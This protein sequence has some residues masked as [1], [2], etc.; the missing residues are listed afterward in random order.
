MAKHI[1]PES[2]ASTPVVEDPHPGS[3][4]DGTHPEAA[5]K[6]PPSSGDP[7]RVKQISSASGDGAELTETGTKQVNTEAPKHP[8]WSANAS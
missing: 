5:E 4:S 2:H 6:K 7:K 1:S 3:I 8:T